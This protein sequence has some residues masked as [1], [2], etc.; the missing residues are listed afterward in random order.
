M[1]KRKGGARCKTDEASSVERVFKKMLA[2]AGFASLEELEARAKSMD[3]D[4]PEFDV[5]LTDIVPEMPS[6]VSCSTPS[7]ALLAPPS[8]TR[9]ISIRV[10]ERVLLKFKAQA[11]TTGTPYQTLMKRALSDASA[12]YL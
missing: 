4:L 6:P 10:H 7:K 1:A 9:R 12:K 2:E 3:C 5:D 11:A 8:G